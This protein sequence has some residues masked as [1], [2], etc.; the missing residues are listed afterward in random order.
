MRTELGISG[1]TCASCVAHVGRALRRVPGVEDAA[2]NLATERASVE[3]A[4]QVT[5][6]ALIAAVRA[7]GYDA[8]PI[9]DELNGSDAM[10]LAASLRAKRALLVLAIALFIPTLILGMAPIAFAGKDWLM[11]AL[12]MPVWLVVGA[13][14]HRSAV[15]GLRSG[16]ANM[17]TLVSLGSTAAFGYS[18]YAT[19]IGQP[20]FF[21]TASAI[22]TL[23]FVG[24][25]LEV[26]ARGRSNH[27]LRELLD[28]RPAM[29]RVRELG[30][31]RTVPLEHV[32]V[33]DELVIAAGE[34]IPVDGVVREGESAI[35]VSML[36]GEPIPIAAAAGTAVKQ[37]T[38][39][40]EGA[41]VVAAQAVGAGTTLAKIIE[42]VRRAQGSMP[43]IQ[44][45]ADRVAAVFV[46]SILAIAAITF[47]AWLASGDA[48]PAALRIAI[49]VLVIACPCALGLATPMAVICGVGAGARRG[50]LFR[51]AQAIERLGSVK[52][53]LFDKTGT[54]TAGKPHVTAIRP[55]LGVD[56]HTVLA[57]AASIE[58]SSTHPLAAAIVGEAEQRGLPLQ[59]ASAIT[60]QP[61]AGIRGSIDG[62]VV[63]A[64]NAAFM[65]RHGIVID[66]SA[67]GEATHVYLARDER[68]LG[69]IDV[70]DSLRPQSSRAVSRLQDDGIDVQIVSGDADAATQGVARALRV[71]RWHARVEPAGKAAIVEH[72]RASGHVVAF[73]GDGINDAPALAL[74]DVG[75][76]MGGGV[77]V[78][79]ETAQVT[80]IS[81]DPQ[82]VAEA[83]ELSRATLRIIKQNLFWA[84]AY[85]V[86]LI[87]L[88][89]AGY[90]HPIFAAA[91]MGVSSLF[92]VGNSLRI[93][94]R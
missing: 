93:G 52:M 37:G 11:L 59:A 73:V 83:I 81:S 65:Q 82:A 66:G 46:P 45:L 24:K 7:A 30:N 5:P 71:K 89:A 72:E 80:I 42:M 16:T 33:G 48:W 13:G 18:V 4:M 91:A 3:H 28:L 88:A 21:E 9:G 51:D 86:L 54:L 32:R 84:C 49:A 85:N 26:A 63:Y 90:V 14:F 15:A 19:V 12:T 43:P 56:E 40:G 1:M 94:R 35:D 10:A 20:S 70:G 50:L 75:I 67:V 36:T 60:A 44:R 25:Y 29:A 47:V 92:V 74:A 38:L 22:V 41:L 61:G 27:A 8:A 34:R 77:E 55:A 53:V 17:D 76:A 69:V 79:M 87:P 2:V 64:G 23:I 68:L 6:A 31:V 62:H 57:T 39:N 78:A 58:Q